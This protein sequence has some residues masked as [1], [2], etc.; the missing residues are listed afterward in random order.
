MFEVIGVLAA[1]TI[2]GA[3]ISAYSSDDPCAPK[4]LPPSFINSSSFDTTMQ[5]ETT[6]KAAG[7]E[8]EVCSGQTLLIQILFLTKLELPNQSKGY[9]VAAG[10]MAAIY[11]ACCAITFFGTKEVAGKL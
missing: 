9:L 2:E 8:K 3:I 10:I 6:T 1:A 11:L 7:F 5:M 4:A